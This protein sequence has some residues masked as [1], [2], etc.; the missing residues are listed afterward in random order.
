MTRYTRWIPLGLLTTILAGCGGGGV[1]EGF[2]TTAKVMEPP[3]DMTKKM[4]ENA[5]QKPRR[6]SAGL[7]PPPLGPTKGRR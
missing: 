5:K 1:Q 4:L 6:A 3:A 2:P 7:T